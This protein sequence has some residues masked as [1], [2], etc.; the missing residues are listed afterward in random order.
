MIRLKVVLNVMLTNTLGIV[1]D[2]CVF[3]RE[4]RQHFGD[5]FSHAGTV[6]QMLILRIFRAMDDEI[7]TAEMS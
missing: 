2:C 5:S 3:D 4:V 1:Y 6:I 7:V